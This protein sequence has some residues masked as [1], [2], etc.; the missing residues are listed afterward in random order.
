[1]EKYFCTKCSHVYLTEDF[2]KRHIIHAHENLRGENAANE[3]RSSG[4]ILNNLCQV[5]GKQFVSSKYLKYHMAVHTG[6]FAFKC[7]QC[8]KSFN[9]SSSLSNHGLRNHKPKVFECDFPDCD[10]KYAALSFLS[11]HI[12]RAHESK[13]YL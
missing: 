3:I 10:K 1:M 12:E 7:D 2:L 11:K 6:E 8:E 13:F 9:T 4:I 5:C